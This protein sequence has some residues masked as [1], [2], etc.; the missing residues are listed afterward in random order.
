MCIRDRLEACRKAIEG[1]SLFSKALIPA[2]A[3]ATAVAGKPVSAVSSSAAAILFCSILVELALR[4]FLPGVYLYIGVTAAGIIARQDV[5]TRVAELIKWACVSFYKVF[6]MIFMGY[7]T[8]SG[9]VSG[10][11]DAAAVKTARVAITG[12]VPVLSLIHILLQFQRAKCKRAGLYFALWKPAIS[13]T[14][15][16][17]HYRPASVQRR[18]R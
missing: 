3:A 16:L 17:C 13:E 9:V 18:Y 10:G 4:V 7:M 1:L 5:L 12:A 11:A 6:L 8:L 2:F 14:A 15:G